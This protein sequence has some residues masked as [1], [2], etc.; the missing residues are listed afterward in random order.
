VGDD[1]DLPDDEPYPLRAPFWF[2]MEGSRDPADVDTETVGMYGLR[3]TD[4]TGADPTGADPTGAEA[5]DQ[6]ATE[7]GREPRCSSWGRTAGCGRSTSTT[8]D[9]FRQVTAG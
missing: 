3:V 8:S 4:P 6:R 2:A 5:A 1:P 9:G 7:A